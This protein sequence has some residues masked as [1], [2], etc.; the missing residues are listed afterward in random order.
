[1]AGF[2]NLPVELYLMI[3]G[4]LDPVARIRCEQVC[5][6]WNVLLKKTKWRKITTF[7]ISVEIIERTFGGEL[8]SPVLIVNNAQ[9]SVGLFPAR[10]A[11]RIEILI[12]QKR[13][14]FVLK[15]N[16]H[17]QLAKILKR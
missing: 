12:V 16:F 4:M 14:D 13:A 9:H 3:F 6:L 11:P 10:G 17:K 5:K 15:A 2:D 8:F 7:N 1:M